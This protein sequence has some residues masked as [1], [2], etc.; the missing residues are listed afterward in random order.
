MTNEVL[1]NKD[2]RIAKKIKNMRGDY[3]K[4]LTKNKSCEDVNI[5]EARF[6]YYL[7]RLEDAYGLEKTIKLIKLSE[8]DLK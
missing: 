3:R 5:A 2:R 7:K 4:A 1:E 8:E 6:N